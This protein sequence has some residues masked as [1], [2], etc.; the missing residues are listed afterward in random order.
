M[1]Q[2]VSNM[3]L[4]AGIV[5]TL[6][7]CNHAENTINHD[8]NDTIEEY[9]PMDGTVVDTLH[10]AQNSL[11]YVGTYVGTLPCADCEGIETRIDLKDDQEYELI[12]TYLGK[13]LDNVSKDMGKYS[14]DETGSVVILESTDNTK[15]KYLFFVGEGTLKQLDQEGNEISG[16]LAENYILSKE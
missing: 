9:I 7:G 5:A 11:D 10:N 6:Y 14:W 12:M 13:G 15:E 3:F 16:A 4:M 1:A 8:R 2:K